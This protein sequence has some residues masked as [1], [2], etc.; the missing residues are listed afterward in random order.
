LVGIALADKSSRQISRFMT[1]LESQPSSRRLRE[2]RV[3]YS[4]AETARSNIPTLKR[5]DDA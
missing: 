3:E 1:C 4:I 5:V 2:D